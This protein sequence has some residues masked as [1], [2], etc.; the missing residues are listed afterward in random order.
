[1]PSHFSASKYFKAPFTE[2]LASNP[3][4]WPYPPLLYLWGHFFPFSWS[5]FWRQTLYHFS[6]LFGSCIQLCLYGVLS[7]TP[8]I[9]NLCANSSSSRHFMRLLCPSPWVTLTHRTVTT[10]HPSARAACYILKR[11]YLLVE[12]KEERKQAWHRGLS[13]L[14]EVYQYFL[15]EE[16]KRRI[17][18]HHALGSSRT[19]E[20]PIAENRNRE[21]RGNHGSHSQKWSHPCQVITEPTSVGLGS[22]TVH[23]LRSKQNVCWW[24]EDVSAKNST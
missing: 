9:S 2:T 7:L 3:S 21:R 18:Q 24:V 11:Q 4:L 23:I 1:M 15:C 19:Y 10:A 13:W 22:A 8:D 20:N 12:Q 6:D 17:L 5:I 16:D 14:C